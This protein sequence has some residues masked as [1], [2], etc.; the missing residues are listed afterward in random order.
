MTRRNR[1]NRRKA[2]RKQRQRDA[3]V[4]SVTEFYLEVAD[5]LNLPPKALPAAVVPPP[6]PQ[7]TRD[8]VLRAIHAKPA[9][10]ATRGF[11]LPALAVLLIVVTA[12]YTWWPAGK[13]TVPEAFR[14]TWTSRN[15]SY[16]GRMIVISMETIEI[17]SG[18][19]AAT[20]PV[21]VTSSIVDTTV[22]G[23]RLRLVYGTTG[24]EQTLVMMLHP[25]QAATLTLLRPADVVWERLE[26]LPAS[27]P[28]AEVTRDS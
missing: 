8:E 4:E 14:G 24:S 13:A 15:P 6:P 9:L 3:T 25:G 12:A 7:Q 18:R 19:T 28:G 16:A 5:S 21:A 26:G 17:V 11:W 2:Q 10:F 20:G 27:P 22:T 23:I 1:A